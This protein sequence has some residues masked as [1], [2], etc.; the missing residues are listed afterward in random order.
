MISC[1][2]TRVASSSALGVVSLDAALPAS[3]ADPA[4]WATMARTFGSVVAQ[5][6]Q[7]WSPWRPL[8]LDIGGGFPAPRDPSNPAKRSAPPLEDFAKSAI[9]AL[10]EALRA[11]RFDPAGVILQIEPGRSLLANTG[12]HLSRVCHVKGQ[13]RPIARTWIELDTTE[14][15]LAGLF[16][17]HAY[18]RPI[19]ASQAETEAVETVEIVGQSCNFDLLA[20]DVE[21]PAVANGDLIAFLDT[22]AYQDAAASNFNALTRPATVLVEANRCT[23]IK[24]RETLEEIFARDL[25]LQRSPHIE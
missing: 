23:L 4:V 14:M 2:C 18:F 22:G 5:L 12:I 1:N 17:E 16:M 15:F 8:E 24:R 11:G 19:F 7:A 6:A 13:D 20:R 3:G 25:P 21:A 10:L 9:G